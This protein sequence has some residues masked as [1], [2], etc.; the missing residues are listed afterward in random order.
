MRKIIKWRA[1]TQKTTNYYIKAIFMILLLITTL[2]V[3]LAIVVKLFFV[4]LQKLQCLML[5]VA[6]RYDLFLS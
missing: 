6:P 4:I 3:I 5:R 1:F 2:F